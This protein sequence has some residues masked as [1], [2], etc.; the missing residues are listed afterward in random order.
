MAE[1][2]DVDV[3]GCVGVV[4]EVEVDF[5]SSVERPPIRESSEATGASSFFSPVC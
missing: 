2:E 3:G 4:D 5:A 1:E